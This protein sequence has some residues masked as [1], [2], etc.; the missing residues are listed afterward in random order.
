MPGWKHIECLAVVQDPISVSMVQCWL[1]RGNLM[2][3]EFLEIPKAS[4]EN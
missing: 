4:L 2:T 3:W 1:G